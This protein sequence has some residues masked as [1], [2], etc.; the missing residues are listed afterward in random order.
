MKPLARHLEEKGLSIDDL[1]AAAGLEAKVVKAI[2]TGN[3]TPSPLQRKKLADALNLSI[4][5][6][7]WGHTVPVEHMYGHGPQ[8]GRTP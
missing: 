7:S 6:I 4:D 5:E 3:Y 8:F 1:I 2:V